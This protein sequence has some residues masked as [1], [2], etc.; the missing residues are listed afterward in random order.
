MDNHLTK[1]EMDIMEVVWKAN[2]KMAPREILAAF[3]E[4][5]KMWKRQTLN[6]LLVRLESKGLIHRERCSVEAA[7]TRQEYMQQQSQVI[8]DTMYDGKLSCFVA[9]LAGGAKINEQ[10]EE[11]LNRLIER[12]KNEG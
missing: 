11:E 3:Y 8:I 10:D 9:A 12:I 1:T 7:C 4:K 2:R 6:T 5:G